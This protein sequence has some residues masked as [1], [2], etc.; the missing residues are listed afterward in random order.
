MA[1]VPHL[2]CAREVRNMNR[3]DLARELVTLSIARGGAALGTSPDGVLRWENG[4]RP[5]RLAQTVMAELF[6]IDPALIDVHPWPQW[7]TFDPLQQNPDHPWTCLGAR[8]AIIETVGS[9]MHRRTFVYSSAALVS[10]LF[11][12]VTADPAVAEQLSGRRL[13]EGAISLIERQVRELRRADDVDGGGTL[14]TRADATLTMV[15]D[16]LSNRSYTL[17][18]GQRLYAAAA[19]LA[20]MRAWGVFDVHDRC[21]DRTFRTALQAAHAADDRLLGAHILTFWAA[22]AYNCDR[23]AEAESLA[24]TALAEVRGKAAARVE[25]LVYARR[26]RARSHIG[27]D[28]CWEDLD[29][30][31]Q[32]LHIANRNAGDEPEWA[33]WFDESEFQGSRASTELA[34]G[35]AEEAE[36]TFAAAARMFNGNAVRTH[37]L[38]L[39]RQADAQRRQ[40]HLEQACDTAHAALDL[41]MEISSQRTIGPLRELAAAMRAHQELPAV[42]D[43]RERIAFAG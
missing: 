25:A 37:A 21:D 39:V 16:L 10:T 41:T 27:D 31:E 22:A 40:G 8:E 26:A 28:G 24:C 29:R 2:V 17:A 33:Y 13:G 9:D 19:D 6:G 43:L 38:Y 20:R 23:P 36:N 35:H 7:L 18:H 11:G 30:A 42:H 4:R 3:R 14:I 1:K 5:D 15:A 34:M 12:W 32:L